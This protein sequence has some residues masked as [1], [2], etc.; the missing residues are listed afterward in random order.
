MDIN[1]FNVDF[2]DFNNTVNEVIDFI[3]KKA[4]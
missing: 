4:K 2:N 3:N 1:W